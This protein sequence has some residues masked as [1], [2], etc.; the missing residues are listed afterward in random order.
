MAITTSPRSLTFSS[1]ATYIWATAF[2]VGNI[3]LPQLCHMVNL[4]GKALL[5]IMLFTLIASARF[6]IRCGLLTAILSPLVSMA[7]FGMPSG[8][9]LAAV[10]L[11][12][13]LIVGVIGTWKEYKGRFSLLSIPLLVIGYQI[14]GFAIEGTIF[15]GFA[16]S[17]SDLL[18][19]WPGALI[20]MIALWAVTRKM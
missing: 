9:M 16:T 10:I 19:S 5:P 18:I 11:K 1:P 6:G 13:L 14:V 20:Q 7:I 3:V 8:I 15:F 12:S 4:G 17:W 2:V